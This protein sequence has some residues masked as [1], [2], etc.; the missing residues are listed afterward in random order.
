MKRMRK[1][2]G[3][4]VKVEKSYNNEQTVWE[5]RFSQR[6]LCSLLP[7]RMWR[8]VLW[9]KLVDVSDELTASIFSV[10]PEDWGSTFLWK[11]GKLLLN[12]TASC[13]KGL[14]FSTLV[15]CFNTCGRNDSFRNSFISRGVMSQ[16][17][18]PSA[19]KFWFPSLSRRPVNCYFNSPLHFMR[20]SLLCV[21]FPFWSSKMLPHT[22]SFIAIR[23]ISLQLNFLCSPK[24]YL[25]TICS[26][27]HLTA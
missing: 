14:L 6:W 23:T 8:L 25:R 1:E 15:T 4:E 2:G 19:V 18:A 10:G 11:L 13:P 17:F 16:L 27:V 26:V 20:V 9:Q 22:Y 21:F 7:L 3:K 24:T 12:Y 5:L